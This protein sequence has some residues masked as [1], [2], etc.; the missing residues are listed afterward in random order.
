MNNS[1]SNAI[2]GYFELEIPK[3][4]VCLSKN[5]LKFQSARASFYSLLNAGMP[6]RVW[7]P[8]YICDAMIA[9]LVVLGIEFVFYGLDENLNVEKSVSLDPQDWLLYVNYFGVCSEQEEKLLS[10][11]NASQV[12][13]DH[14]QAF[15]APPQ[16]CLAT[17]YSPRKFFGVPDGGLLV[18]SLSVKVPKKVDNGSVAR[19]THLLKRLDTTPEAGYPDFEIAED[20]LNNAEP[21]R[22]SHL[23]ELLITSIDHDKVRQLRNTNFQYLHMYLKSINKLDLNLLNADGP[24]CY[25]LRID[26][27]KLR[28]SLISK[29]VFVATYWPEVL[30]RASVNSIESQLVEECLPIPCDQRYS[31]LEMEKIIKLIMRFL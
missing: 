12:I 9:P 23:S 8:R 21:Y 14:S 4:I 24:L 28:E 27:P 20:T 7:M 25:P 5:T 16:K 18:T 1:L 3:D 30:K 13:L 10:R 17:I 31:A 2:G 19:C 26:S 6:N 11:F 15:F 22:M 29:R